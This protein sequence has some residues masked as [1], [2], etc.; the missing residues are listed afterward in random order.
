[1]LMRVI[2][3]SSVTSRSCGRVTIGSGAPGCLAIRFNRARP[4][5]KYAASAPVRSAE[6]TMRKSRSASCRSKESSTAEVLESS[7]HGDLATVPVDPAYAATAG[8]LTDRRQHGTGESC[9]QPLERRAVT[10]H[11]Q[12]VV[13]AASG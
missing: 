13:F 12:L 9:A 7:G 6:H 8:D 10:C 11:Q 5:E 2:P 3:T 1:M 4:S